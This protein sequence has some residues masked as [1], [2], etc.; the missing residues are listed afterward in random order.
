MYDPLKCLKM[1]KYTFLILYIS[2]LCQVIDFK[3]KENY[4]LN[5]HLLNALKSSLVIFDILI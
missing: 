1:K 4:S 3:I 2:H 5:T